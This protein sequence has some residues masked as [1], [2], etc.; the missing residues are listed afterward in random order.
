LNT[1]GSVYRTGAP[2]QHTN[3]KNQYE[4]PQENLKSFISIAPNYKML[5]PC[6]FDFC[7]KSA[8]VSGEKMFSFQV[9]VVIFAP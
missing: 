3:A 5:K 7:G 4:K 2:K 1:E 6:P 8:G 9:R